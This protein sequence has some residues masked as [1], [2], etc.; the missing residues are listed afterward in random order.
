MREKARIG[1]WLIWGAFVLAWTFCLVTP[2]PVQMGRAVLPATADFPLSKVVHV[3]G[4]AFL[5]V[6]SAWL[7]APG[8]WRWLLLAFLA[9][10]GP[11]T[12]FVQRWV[13]ERTASVYDVLLDWA[14]IAIG[15]G[16]SWRWW[17]RAERAS[18]VSG[19]RP[20]PR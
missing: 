9:L 8:G 14:G 1:R 2:Y 17:V 5:T 11:A 12:E 19:G 18:R 13:P 6:L 16:L 4:Y 15:F 7:R 20:S 3:A 10:H